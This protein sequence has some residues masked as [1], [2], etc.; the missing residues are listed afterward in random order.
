MTKKPTLLGSIKAKLISAT[1][2]LLVAVIMVV[3][4][5]YAWFTLSTAPEVTGITTAVGA[6]GALEMALYVGDPNIKTSSGAL[7]TGEDINTYW[8]NLVDLSGA[9]YGLQ[10]VVLYPSILNPGAATNSLNTSKF[11]QTPKYGTDGRVSELVA[12]AMTGRYDAQSKGFLAITEGDGFGVRA[13]G[14]ASGMTPRQHAYRNA[15]ADAST[16]MSKAQTLAA[17]SLNNN[18]SKL[19]NIALKHGTANGTDTYTQADL[20]T[21]KPIIDAYTADG[22]VL[23]QLDAAYMNYVL[24]YVAG[25]AMTDENAENYHVLVKGMMD[26]ADNLSAF[27]TAIQN[28]STANGEGVVEWPGKT[29]PDS[30]KTYL[31]KVIATRTAVETAAATW[32]TLD[33]TVRPESSAGANDAV[34]ATWSDIRP[35]LA[36]FADPEA[37]EINGVKAGEV[38]ENMSDLVNSVAGNGLQITIATGGG[39]YADVAD[40]C[41]DYSA[42][43]V[44]EKVEYNGLA[45]NN[46]NARMKTNGYLTYTTTGEGEEA[47][48]TATKGSAPYLVEIKNGMTG[49]SAYPTG[50]AD[51]DLP[52]TEFYGYIMD[53]AFRTNAA[54]SNLLLQAD[55]TDRIYSDN[56]NEETM[57]HGSSMTFKSTT[58]D[59]SDAQVKALMDAI[60]IV[61]FDPA[62]GTIYAEA[63]LDTS[64]TGATFGPDGW[65]AKMYVA[66]TE[67]VYDV[68]VDENTTKTCYRKTITTTTGEEGAQTTTTTYEYYENKDLTGTAVVPMTGSTPT[69]KT[70]IAKDDDNAIV[71]L[72]QGQN[73]YVSAMVYLDGNA[74]D[75]SKVA[76][77]AASSMTG[78]M[79]LQFSS[80]ANLVPMEYADLHTSNVDTENIE[81]TVGGT[82]YTIPGHVTGKTYSSSVQN[83]A[84]VSDSGTIT[85]VAPGTATITVKENGATVKKFNVVV[86]AAS[87]NPTP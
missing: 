9:N 45:L 28:P 47:V 36:A 67:T 8:G 55:A 34:T 66:V 33:G 13:L 23:D 86:T 68:K 43:V 39:A 84:T 81:L 41:G 21:I 73:T 1:C 83:V 18:G 70:R 56:S 19:A 58:T 69:E 12:E 76:A 44:I 60:R 71:A 87:A 5:T 79:N 42:A 72:P 22:G 59:F 4:S 40:H 37:M 38:K 2:M 65:T 16:A 6:N 57:G 46:M 15:L 27:M 20:D 50:A 61:F 32:T 11:L 77:T 80:S 62:Q 53:L 25:A 48:T 26:S 54:E 75:N 49:I 3:S 35:I 64:A 74:I 82:P 29:I 24:A 63:R 51:G 52:M 14:I 30:I 78:K 10:H 31:D 7:A 85:A 17:Q